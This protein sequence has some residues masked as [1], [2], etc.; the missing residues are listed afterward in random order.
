M[1]IKARDGGVQ[2]S[3]NSLWEIIGN[4]RFSGCH[5]NPKQTEDLDLNILR[6]IDKEVERGAI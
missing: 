6:E 5:I 3:S 4:K 1:P 2:K